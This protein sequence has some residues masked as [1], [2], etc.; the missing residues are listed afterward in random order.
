[1]LGEVTELTS[2]GVAGPARHDGGPSSFAHERG[3]ARSLSPS[4]A[5]PTLALAAALPGA[6]VAL[7]FAGLRGQVPLWGCAALLTVVSYA[8]YTLVHEAIHGNIVRRP[9]RFAWVN[10]LVGWVGALGLGGSWPLL[11]RTHLLH[12]AHTNSE[13]DPDVYWKGSLIRLARKWGKAILMSFVPLVALRLTHPKRLARMRAALGDPIVRY[14]SMVSVAHCFLLGAAVAT[15][16]LL[17]YVCLWLA[18]TK[19][20]MLAL[21]ILFQWLPHHPFEETSRY[22]NTRLSLWPGATLAT[23]QQNLHLVHHLWPGVPFYNYRRLFTALRPVLDA[24]GARSEG[25]IAG[26]PPR[27]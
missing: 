8:H 23:L 3:L 17:A 21:H 2:R 11:R 12:H 26:S 22:R 18:P 15:G 27:G 16:H 13:R 5:W 6:F 4:V 1:M 14:T 20:A 9:S 19:L 10:S 7:A 25:L 24:R